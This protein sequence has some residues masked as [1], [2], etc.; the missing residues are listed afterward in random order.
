MLVDTKGEG[1]NNIIA[2]VLF[3]YTLQVVVD[4]ET[5]L[6]TDKLS[7]VAITECRQ[8]GSSATTVSEITR[9]KDDCVLKL[10]KRGIDKANKQAVSR[11][12]KVQNYCTTYCTNNFSQVTK[13]YI[14]DTDFSIAG[15][16]LSEFFKLVN[17]YNSFFQLAPTLK[18]KRPVVLNKYSEIIKTLY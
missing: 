6:P 13:W 14:L 7:D 9:G 10:I 1:M 8:A 11:A 2:V 5:G 4:D 3:V 17:C 15:G 16:E 12:H 18:L